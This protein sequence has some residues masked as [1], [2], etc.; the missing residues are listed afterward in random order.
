MPFYTAGRV[1][2]PF[3]FWG[4]VMQQPQEKRAAIDAAA[5]ARVARDLAL[6]QKQPLITNWEELR[7]RG[8]TLKQMHQ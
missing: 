7:T 6:R 2:R 4:M 1:E 3:S 8:E 5:R